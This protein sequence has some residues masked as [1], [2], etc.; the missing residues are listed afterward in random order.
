MTTDV[1]EWGATCTNRNLTLTLKRTSATV[2]NKTSY[3]HDVFQSLTAKEILMDGTYVIST[4]ECVPA[5]GSKGSIQLLMH[6]ATYTK[7]MWEFAY[8][9]ERYGWTRKFNLE[10]YTTLAFDSLG[11]SLHHSAPPADFSGAGNSTR[12][13]AIHEVQTQAHVEMVRQIIDMLRAGQI[14]GK[15]WKR[16]IFVGFSI[17]AAAGNSLATQYPTAADQTIL[18]GLSWYE[19]YVYPALL[20]MKRDQ[21]NKI[22]KTRWGNIPDFYTTM[23][24][25]VTRDFSHLYGEYDPAVSEVDYR[26]L[27]VDTLGEAV[28]FFFHADYAPEYRNSVFLAV[29][30]S[31]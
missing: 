10:G 8:K 28:S 2:F 14:G 15:V 23:P 1:T 5:N 17:G 22:N 21:A 6:G 7:H 26:D 24:S 19:K 27:D 30:N 31:M 13:D 4:R 20:Y 25:L 9:P 16:V 18:L 29:G 12:P 3:G 11:M